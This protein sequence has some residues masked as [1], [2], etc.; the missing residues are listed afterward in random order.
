MVDL[1][2]R[3]LPSKAD[4]PTTYLKNIYGSYLRLLPSVTY[5]TDPRFA[6][7]TVVIMAADQAVPAA[8]RR[9]DSTGLAAALRSNGRL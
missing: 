1:L 6:I 2:S 8:L 7:Q 9:L 5:Q 4:K 3:G